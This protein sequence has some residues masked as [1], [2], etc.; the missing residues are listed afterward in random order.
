M[1]TDFFEEELQKAQQRFNSTFGMLAVCNINE[2]SKTI[3]KICQM[4]RLKCKIV[5]SKDKDCVRDEIQQF[6]RIRNNLDHIFDQIDEFI[7]ERCR[8]Q[9][10]EPFL[11]PEEVTS[12]KNSS[13]K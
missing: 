1:T 8:T 12:W 6:M 4:G 3:L 2:R 9:G 7:S 13:C 5:S 10:P 11:I